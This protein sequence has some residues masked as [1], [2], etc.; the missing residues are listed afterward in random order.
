ML[1]RKP[2]RVIEQAERRAIRLVVAVE[3]LGQHLVHAV[4]R[5]RIL[6]RVTHRAAA[7]A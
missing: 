5:F 3:V 4:F 1:F 2:R 6:T 7:A